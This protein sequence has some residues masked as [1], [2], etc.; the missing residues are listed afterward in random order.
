[1]Y[2]TLGCRRY[3]QKGGINIIQN[4]NDIIIKMKLMIK[5]YSLPLMQWT[6]S[7]LMFSFT[8]LFILLGDIIYIAVWLSVNTEKQSL[9]IQ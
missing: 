4:L 1:M 7:F 9:A 5:Q 3:V 2:N 8:L 6:V